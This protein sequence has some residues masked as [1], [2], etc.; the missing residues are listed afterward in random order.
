MRKLVILMLVF[1][2]ASAANA[3]LHI[4]VGGNTNPKSSDIWLTVSQ[5]ITIDV[6][7][8]AIMKAGDDLAGYA[9]VSNTQLGAMTAGAITTKYAPLSGF[10]LYQDAVS[11]GFPGLAAGDNGPWG[12]MLFTGE[13]PQVDAGDVIID[14][15]ILHC[16]GPGDVTIKLYSTDWGTAQLLDSVIIHQV[17]E[18]MTVALLGLGGL[19]LLRR[20]K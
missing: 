4:S 20:R 7:S 13:V 9:I 10:V 17:P 5:E 1:G 2:I 14:G 8:D 11:S 12:T 6:W 16:K 19:F 3:A 15:I 18:P